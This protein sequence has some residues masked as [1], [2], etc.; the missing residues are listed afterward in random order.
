MKHLLRDNSSLASARDS[1]G[2]SPLEIA[3]DAEYRQ[4]KVAMINILRDAVLQDTIEYSSTISSSKGES[5][6]NNNDDDDD[7]AN[8][9]GASNVENQTATR[10]NGGEYTQT[11]EELKEEVLNLQN[12][13]AYIKASVDDQL[14]L[15]WK[16]VNTALGE[17]EQKIG[18]LER[19]TG[20][21][22]TGTLSEESSN[23]EDESRNDKSTLETV[24]ADNRRL[25]EELERLDEVYDVH[26]FKVETVEKIIKDLADTITKIATGHNAVIARLK[27][28]ERELIKMSQLRSAKLKELSNEV[29]AITQKLTSSSI[30]KEEKKAFDV[31]K[32]EQEILV[33][34]GDIIRVLKS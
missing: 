13:K 6:D 25:E 10:S 5:F 32:K 17:I 33:T 27:K 22:T 4:G 24:K 29:D 34:M 15:E 28:K 8:F 26:L 2:L 3:I 1:E 11:T 9:D 20:S 21:E 7:D 12:K 23:P 19:K 31:L 16:A 18:K 14:K 30:E